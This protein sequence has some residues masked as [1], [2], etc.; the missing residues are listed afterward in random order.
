MNIWTKLDFQNP[1]QH[2]P[3]CEVYKQA[4]GRTLVECNFS[5]YCPKNLAC[6][7]KK[8]HGWS[9]RQRYNAI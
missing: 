8:L 5:T 2:E 3:Q 6:H 7:L 9:N 1:V 4:I